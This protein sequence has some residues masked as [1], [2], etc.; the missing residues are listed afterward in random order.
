MPDIIMDLISNFGFPIAC[1]C[2]LFW[3]MIK[4]D[5]AHKEEINAMKNALENNTLVLTRLCERFDKEK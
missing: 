4:Q 1:C 2:A 3:R 5:E